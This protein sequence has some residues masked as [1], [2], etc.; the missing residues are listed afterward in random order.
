MIKRDD[1]VSFLNDYFLVEKYGPDSAM[2]RFVPLVYENF[3]WKNY[4]TEYFQT[5]YNGLMM[6]GGNEVNHIFGSVFPTEAVLSSFINESEP[7]DFLFLHHPIDMECGD[8]QGRYGR[9]ALPIKP[10]QLEK[11]KA[12][13]LSVY[14]CHH[15]LDCHNEISTG[16]AI[17]NR[18]SLNNITPFVNLAGGFVGII[19]DIENI[20]SKDL[21]KKLKNIFNL[22]YLDLGGVDKDCIQKVSIIAGGG[23]KID[24]FREAEEMGVEAYISGE[25]HSHIDNEKGK[26]KMKEA[27]D[28]IKDSK[29]SFFGVSHAASEFLVVKE[30]VLPLLAH[31]FN[32]P[33]KDI[34]LDNWWH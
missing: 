2:S 30:M 3:N 10:E 4:F 11:M 22:P 1:L 9:F 12:K 6:S 26:I 24:F 16:L 32:L 18:L 23:D 20:S 25:I 13:Q 29:M 7:G 14:S 28:Y 21:I 34:P 8:P 17:A 31:Q 19:G 5:Y 27:L 15:P 33:V